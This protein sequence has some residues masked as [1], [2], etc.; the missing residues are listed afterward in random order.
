L[1]YYAFSNVRGSK[2]DHSAQ[3]NA[4]DG[5]ENLL[6]E[7]DA[8]NPGVE[9]AVHSLSFGPVSYLALSGNYIRNPDPD[10]NNSGYLIKASL[11]RLPSE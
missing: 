9:L 4:R 2:L 11:S 10:E 8:L 3:T 7:Y 1:A 6:Y 5:D